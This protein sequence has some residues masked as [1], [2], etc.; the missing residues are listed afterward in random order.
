MVVALKVETSELGNEF[1]LFTATGTVLKKIQK[2]G[3]NKVSRKVN[4][5]STKK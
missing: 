3:K 2:G 4:K 1:V 5:K